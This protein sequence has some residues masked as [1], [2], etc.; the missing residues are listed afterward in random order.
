MTPPH[1]KPT[2]KRK[3]IGQQSKKQ[4]ADNR[5]G[6]YERDGEQC[7]VA[8]SLWA[9]LFPCEGPLTI[10]HGVG[11][12]MGGSAEFDGPECLRTMC[13]GHNDQQ[14]KS[15]AFAKECIWFGW[16][17][18]RGRRGLDYTKVPVRYPNGRDYLLTTDF[19]RELL[20]LTEAANLRASIHGTRQ[21]GQSDPTG[22]S[23]HYA[24]GENRVSWPASER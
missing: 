24:E 6:V 19:K 18:E 11:K 4:V 2:R 7:V 22:Q 21:I 16:A 3:T 15:S 9:R 13:L 5:A 20:P 14:P 1:P 8:G 23:A 12:G 17:I 10:Q